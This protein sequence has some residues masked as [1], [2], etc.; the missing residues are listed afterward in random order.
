MGQS[1]SFMYCVRVYTYTY[2]CACPGMHVEDREQLSGVCFFLLS[3]G[4]LELNSH[5]ELGGKNL[6]LPGPRLR[7]L[8]T[9][10]ARSPG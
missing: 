4:S 6:Y 10:S 8:I 2:T 9:D 7:V 5:P 1:F 3:R